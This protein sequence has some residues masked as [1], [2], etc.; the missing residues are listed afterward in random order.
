MDKIKTRLKFS[1][2][3]VGVVLVVCLGVNYIAWTVTGGPLLPTTQE[4][5]R[6]IFASFL[7]E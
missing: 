2:L 5:G 7:D 1:G 4:M 6:N 3:I